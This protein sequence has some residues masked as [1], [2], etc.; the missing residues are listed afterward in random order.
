MKLI[1]SMIKQIR[2]KSIV[3]VLLLL[4]KAA[5]IIV[6]ADGTDG[7]IRYLISLS[8][9]KHYPVQEL[10]FYCLKLAVVIP[11]IYFLYKWVRGL[12][13]KGALNRAIIIFI[14]VSVFTVWAN[15]SILGI[16]FWNGPYWGRVVDADTG[17]PIVGAVVVGI[18]EFEYYLFVHGSSTYADARETVT[19]EKGRFFLQPTRKIWLWPFSRI[20]LSKLNVFKPGYDS[21]PPSMQFA[22]SDEDSKKWLPELNL[23]Y[24]E[25]REKYSQTYHS[26][27]AEEYFS[28]PRFASTI[29]YSIFR[30][31]CKSY[32]ESIIR[33]NKVGSSK[34]RRKVA[35]LS[36]WN[37]PDR[38][39][40]PKMVEV[41]NSERK[42]VG[43]RGRY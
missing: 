18:W 12:H 36:L 41:L 25:Y 26:K 38:Y 21:H 39:K 27:D 6:L 32:K 20:V 8:S 37:V 13:K 14:L 33:L 1:D 40:I 43:M 29:Y 10:I 28:N 23:R 16:F 3:D 24:P 19:N 42:R 7:A 2:V 4:F 34:E 11:I 15:G 9:K 31:K 17:E 30:V 5:I 35:G 22:W